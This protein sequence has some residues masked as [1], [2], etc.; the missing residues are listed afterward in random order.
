[1]SWENFFSRS[2]QKP[3]QHWNREEFESFSRRKEKQVEQA[4]KVLL[5]NFP[6]S[7]NWSC[8]SNQYL[9]QYTFLQE[10][11][12]FYI[13][14]VLYSKLFLIPALRFHCVGGCWTVATLALAWQS[15]ALTT[16]PDLSAIPAINTQ[17]RLLK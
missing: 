5:E 8:A 3:E 16:R 10:W 1:M 17:P 11:S 2:T 13:F 6:F 15:D 4:V 14:Y 7:E 9:L 12:I